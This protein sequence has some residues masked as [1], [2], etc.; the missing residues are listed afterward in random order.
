MAI[1]SRSKGNS[2][3]RKVAKLMEVWTGKKFARVPSSGG[4]QWKAAHAKGDIT[5]ASE[6]HYFPFCME[7]KSYGELNF[8][9]LLYL[10][11]A[12]ILKFWAQCTRDAKIC[13]KTPLLF[14]RYNGLPKDFWFIAIPLKIY[15]QFFSKLLKRPQTLRSEYHKFI[16]LT[17]KDFFKIPYKEIRKPIKSYNKLNPAK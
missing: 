9:H 7:V 12:D 11:K 5:C 8:E 10:E 16:L 6:G 15:N 2:A 1:N 13:N 17:S 3:E 4:L 14:M